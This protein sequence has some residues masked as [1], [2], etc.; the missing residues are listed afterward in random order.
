MGIIRYSFQA[1]DT[2]D[3]PTV[4]RGE[5]KGS[6]TSSASLKGQGAG[7]SFLLR[8]QP[9]SHLTSLTPVSSLLGLGLL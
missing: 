1:V 3:I 4:I 5:A 2:L 8:H 9:E 7:Y 6:E